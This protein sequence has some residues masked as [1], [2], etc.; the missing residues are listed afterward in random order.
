MKIFLDPNTFCYSPEEWEGTAAFDRMRRLISFLEN[1]AIEE[2][3]LEVKAKVKIWL[4]DSIMVAAY[5]LNPTINTPP[6][7]FYLRQYTSKLLPAL[8]RRKFAPEMPQPGAIRASDVLQILDC[9]IEEALICAL[10]EV[11][12]TEISNF[13]FLFDSSRVSLGVAPNVFSA[14]LDIDGENGRCF[15][16]ECDLFPLTDKSSPESAIVAAVEVLKSKLA[17]EDPTWDDYSVSRAFLHEAF[18]P[19]VRR[20][21]WRSSEMIY[22]PRIIYALLQILTGRNLTINEHSMSPQ[23]IQYA[24]GSHGKWNAY[25]FRNGPSEID[26]RCSR[27]YYA[28]IDGGVLLYEYDGDAH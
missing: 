26:T 28:K 4:N 6:R 11:S 13:A 22:Y 20:A 7:P 12:V 27:I 10:D 25:V 16:D 17:S 5:G 15:L 9:V 21:D 19:S 24:G 8:M 2:E 14:E 18:L 23:R 1:L 3:R